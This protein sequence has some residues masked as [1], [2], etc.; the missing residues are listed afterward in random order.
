[1]ANH[2]VPGYYMIR[3]IFRGGM[4]DIYVA[5]DPAGQRVIVRFLKETYARDRRI[6]KQFL[7]GISV[8]THVQHRHVVRLFDHGI[9]DDLPYMVMEYLNGCTL[10]DL[11]IRKDPLIGY[12]LIPLMRQMAEAL[13]WV[14]YKNYL[15]LDYKPENLMVSP[16]RDIT[17]IDF[18]LAM[19]HNG[20]P[21]A[22]KEITGTPAYIAPE[23]LRDKKA[24]ETADIFSFGVCCYEMMTGRKPFERD[25]QDGSLRAQMDSGVE[26]TPPTQYAPTLPSSL[27][28]LVLKCLAKDVAKRYPSMSLVLKSLENWI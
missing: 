1:M 6:R 19:K 27:E 14:H 8:L 4:T 17:L 18:D 15:H 25:T 12:D 9:V 11:L 13:Y 28:D 10:R 16:D 7:H 22:L 26:A 21:V 23:C 2:H 3:P 20:K 5:T 24:D